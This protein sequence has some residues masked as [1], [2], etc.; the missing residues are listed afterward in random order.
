LIKSNLSKLMERN[1]PRVT[2]RALEAKTCLAQ[3]TIVR[4]RTDDGIAGCSLN[5][6]EKIARALKV[7]VHDLFEDEPG[8]EA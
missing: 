2:I 1:E 7:S 6:L 8:E 5:T 4:A 3:A